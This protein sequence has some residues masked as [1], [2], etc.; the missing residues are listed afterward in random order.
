MTELTDKLMS[1]ESPEAFLREN[2]PFEWQMFSVLKSEVDRLVTCDLNE[3]A[4][5]TDRVEEL[6]GLVGDPVSKAFAQGSR[7]RVL[8]GSGRHS[9]A[10]ALYDDAV[11]AMRSANLRNEAAI[12]QKPQVA[13]LL[14]MG[15][16]EDALRTARQ[17]RRVLSRGEPVEL[18]QLDTNIGHIYYRLDR[19]GKALEHYDRARGVLEASGD[20]TMCALVDFSRSNV[21]AELDRPDEALALLENAAAVFERAGKSLQAAQSR[22]H[23]AYLQFQRGNYNTALAGYYS[24]RDRLS[25]LG[26]TELVAHCNLEVAEILLALNSFED[27]HESAGTARSSF[28]ELGMPY[29]E[30]RSS[31][32]QALAL[33]GLGRIEQAQQ[34]LTRAREAFADAGNRTFTALADS[35]LA[36][37]AIRK[38]DS[39]EASRRAALSLRVFGRQKLA[40]RS[41]YARLLGARAAFHIGDVRKATRL[42]RAAL[43]SARDLGARAVAYQCHHLIGRIERGRGRRRQALD[44][45]RLAV[46][47]IERMRT[48]VAADEFKAIFLQDKIE[49]YEDAIRECLDQANESAVEEAFTLVESCKS[50]AL[51][52]LLARYA[53][54]SEETSG[55]SL[56]AEAR[57][58]LARLIED[59]NWYSS[60]AN[61]EDNKGD[62]RRVETAERYRLEVARCER[63]IT[64][65]FRRLE[66]EGLGPAEMQGR[67]AV[68]TSDLCS[69]LEAGETAIEFF[70]TG[71]QVSAF[72][73]SP[74]GIKVRRAIASRSD[75]ERAISAM[76]F[77][78]D[79]FNYGAAYV[80][81]HFG[82]LK[83]ALNEHLRTLYNLVFAPV[84]SV[85]DGD[86][87]IVIPHGALHY[88]PFHALCT[89][90]DYLVDRFEISYAASTAVLKLCRTPATPQ[91]RQLAAI[92]ATNS[93]VALGVA[94]RGTPGIQDEIDSLGSLFPKAVKLV[95]NDATWENLMRAAPSARFLHLASHG[96]FRRDNPMFSFLKLADSHLNFYSLLDLTLNAELV[97]L[98]ACHTGM[99]KVFPGDELQG[100]MR[101]FLH[102]GARSLVVSLWAVGDRSTADLM[103]EMYSDI[104]AGKSKRAALRRA[105]L[106]IKQEY[107]HPYYWAPFVLM[108]DPG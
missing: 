63:Q 33:M 102:A 19:Y 5:L 58:R 10:N 32:V 11:K 89:G 12:I 41:S 51:A 17:A 39:A 31:Q 81:E 68:T 46:E 94:E 66:A 70:T 29:D 54:H 92:P 99:N 106:A 20:E 80:D 84:E 98:S 61:L 108:G 24:A 16:Y 86:R 73:A 30:A 43:V 85:L 28:K 90:A 103:R 7:A 49:T 75:V 36:D 104:C 67:S 38:G 64:L 77:Q 15:R 2:G 14:M 100:L 59:L 18:A 44:N 50:R 78:L 82:Q 105:Q 9:E 52:D 34:D 101:G 83:R 60:H 76:R 93:F 79:K 107:G 21:L 53:R 57:Q 40:S 26:S 74:R 48:G 47:V 97:T 22:F 71:D 69:V 1:A 88:L 4:R 23:I 3:A 37:L 87:L 25:K 45:F 72:I 91:R 35:Y 55:S 6:A 96:Y 8:Y 62:Q 95:G 56:E 13:A 27:A 65:L 42:A